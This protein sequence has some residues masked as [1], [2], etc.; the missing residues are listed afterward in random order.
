[1]LKIIKTLSPTVQRKLRNQ[2]NRYRHLLE[3]DVSSYAVGRQRFWLEHQPIL[4]S[5]GKHY[6]R[7]AQLPGL[8]QYCQQLYA[9]A[10][11]QAGLESPP[12]VVLGLAAYGPI[13][14]KKHRDDLY[15]ACPAVSINLSTR[16]TRWGYTPSYPEYQHLHPTAAE[17][18]IYTLPPGTVIL[19]NSQNLHRVV[20]A[21]PERWSVN[22]WSLEPKCQLYFNQY[23]QQLLPTPAGQ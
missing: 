7:G 3:P 8:W 23:L 1:M 19:F 17:E 14:I 4:G 22:L 5:Y 6:Q 16:P 18:V 2:L 20:E 10:M 15:A 9:E 21:D 12:S 13:G 11:T